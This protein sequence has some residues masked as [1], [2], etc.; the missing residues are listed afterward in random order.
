MGR[1]YYRLKEVD[2]DGQSFYHEI[3]SVM[4]VKNGESFVA[5]ASATDIKILLNSL[6]GRFTIRIFSADGR[7][8]LQKECISGGMLQEQLPRPTRP[9]IYHVI[10]S[11]EKIQ[12]NRTLAIR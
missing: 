11:G 6:K 2:T 12:L 3:R 1:N 9:G 5:F 4:V 7:P 10:L 8:V